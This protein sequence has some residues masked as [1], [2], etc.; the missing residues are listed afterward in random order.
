MRCCA[1]VQAHPIRSEM[2]VKIS[3]IT[4]ASAQ[5]RQGNRV[6]ARRW[7]RILRALGHRVT[8]AQEYDGKPCD[9]MIALHARHSH[10]SIERFHHLHP[11]LPLILAL[12]GTDLYNDIHTDQQAQQSLQ[13]ADRLIVLQPRGIDEL[14]LSL[15]P[16]VR[17]IYQSAVA[18]TRMI[19]KPKSTF[20]ICVLGHL[21]PVKDP[22][23]TAAATRFLPSSSRIRVLHV[24]KALTP[25]MAERAEAEAA[26]N[27]RYRW[28]GELPRWRAL[29]VLARSH[30]MVLSSTMEGGANAISEALVRSVP[31]LASQISGSVGLLGAHYPGYFPVADTLAVK[32]LLER[33]E[34][35]TGFYNKLMDWC[36]RRVELV[37]PACE[38]QAWEKLLNEF[39]P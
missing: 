20:D 2:N 37:H 14:H 18:P 4:P 26:S 22:F 36:A 8:I 24:G 30:V 25:D 29:Q 34:T 27:S 12:T 31:I 7:G 15:H 33:V 28:L 32:Y 23:R 16:K 3:L 35:D 6:T 19:P 39:S 9:L 13:M 21:R 38:Q 1:H 11:D 5:S 10:L 17:V